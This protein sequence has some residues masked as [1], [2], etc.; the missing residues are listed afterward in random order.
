[1]RTSEWIVLG[2]L[3]YLA[4]AARA[5]RLPEARRRAILLVAILVA[6]VIVGLASR[7]VTL[8]MDVARDWA[9]G[10]YLLVGFWLSGL[11][12]QG[13]NIEL[14]AW[15]EEVDLGLWEELGLAAGSARLP[16]AVSGI[17]EFAYLFCYPVVPGGIA[18]LYLSGHRGQADAYWTAVLAA[19]YLSY[20]TLPFFVTRPPR[21]MER[22][23]SD[24]QPPRALRRLNL[25]I[26]RHASIQVNTLPSGHAAV[27]FAAALAL[28]G[29][30]PL[31]GAAF[32]AVACAIAIGAVVGRYHYALDVVLGAL[33]GVL[34]AF[35]QAMLAG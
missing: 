35:A 32:G 28:G 30:M 31:T 17:L 1:M 11:F 14:E 21:S 12:N 6:A 3:L 5:R 7:P 15:L 29:P 34:A 24:Q 9:P 25:V 19:A 13:A 27:A 10:I 18:A 23:V 8:A 16:R 33:V 4:V 26:L 20:G 22:Q 2:Y